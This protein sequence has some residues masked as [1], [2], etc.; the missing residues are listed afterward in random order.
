VSGTG[1]DSG[2]CTRG[3]PC[4]TFAF[5]HG[6]TD[7][8]GEINCIDVGNFGPVTI[9]KAITIDCGGTLGGISPGASDAI[10]INS[11]NAVVRLRNLSLNGNGTGFT[12][13]RFLNGAALFVENCNIANFNGGS[14]GQGSA[15][16]FAPPAGVTAELYLVDSVISSN[17]RASDGGGIVIQP[18]GTGSA[19]VAV[20][21]TRIEN[22]TLGLFADGTGSAGLIAVQL[23]DSLVSE[24]KL[25]G[26]AALTAAGGSIASISIE[27]SSS[28]LN[29]N[30]GVQAQGPGSYVTLAD[31]TVMSN[32]AGLSPSSGGTIL[33][34]GD[35]QLTGN[36]SDG[37][38]TALFSV[39]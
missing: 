29:G 7:S 39:R 32:V 34:Y 12:G 16:V 6:Q 8:G 30:A 9:A 20:E 33:S 5:A 19:R 38:A 3:A 15:I 28:L 18:V 1:T 13:I 31:S 24:S 4:L 35:N 2:T 17:G 26:V 21:R 36:A 10:T 23:R 22:N 25:T 11:A 14:P 27:R 37:G